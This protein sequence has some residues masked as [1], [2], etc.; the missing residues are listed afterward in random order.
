MKTTESIKTTNN[1]VITLYTMS[2]LERYEEEVMEA[3]VKG[4]RDCP[5][6]VDQFKLI[7]RYQAFVSAR[8]K[9]IL[10]E[11]RMHKNE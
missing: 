3:M 7:E 1:F 8:A 2:N 4:I 9:R 6:P 5:D 10:S 11:E